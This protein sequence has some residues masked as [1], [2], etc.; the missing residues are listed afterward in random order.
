MAQ[1]VISALEVKPLG[2][3]IDCNVGEGGHSLAIL[4]AVTPT[5]RLLGID[6]DA[7][8]LTIA[9]RRLEAYQ[10]T[11][12]LVQGNF[13]DVGAIAEEHGFEPADGIL[14]DLGLS[15]LQVDTG[16]RGFSFRQEARL[17]MRFDPGQEITAYNVVNEYS[18]ESLADVIF[19]LGEERKSRRVARAIVRKRPIETT[20]QLADVITHALG[21]PA[22][23]RIHPATRT[24]QAIRMAVNKELDNLER[25]LEQA[26]ELLRSGGRVAVISY[27]SLEDRLVKNKL[28]HEASD[29]ICPPETPICVCGHKA[30]IRLVNRK[31]I[32]PTQAE[33]QAN[34][35]SRSARMRVAERI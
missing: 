11:V 6:L 33:V 7:E 12:V 19:R 5:P 21:W 32:K 14:F 34:P 28:R 16:S 29:C 8:S 26:L 27:H 24:F 31:V 15:S 3:F 10:D 4:S 30:S 22:K 20:I 2:A 1:E 9:R 18:E 25:G 13:A 35:R 23:G 17:D